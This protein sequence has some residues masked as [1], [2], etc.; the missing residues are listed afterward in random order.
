M[1]PI[2]VV[3][4]TNEAGVFAFPHGLGRRPAS[5]V[6]D[7]RDEH[8]AMEFT[9]FDDTLARGVLRMRDSGDPVP[10]AAFTARFVAVG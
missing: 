1:E 9:G 2:E 3:T 5:L 8:V 7:M 4:E 10:S 6:P